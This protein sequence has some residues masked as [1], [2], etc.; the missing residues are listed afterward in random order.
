[1]KPGRWPGIVLAALIAATAVFFAVTPRPKPDFSKGETL[2]YE[3]AVREILRPLEYSGFPYI[4]KPEAAL[5]IDFQRHRWTLH[6]MR[7]YDPR[8]GVL[9]EQ[10]RYGLCAELASHVYQKL[11]PL[12]NKHYTL[13]FVK[14]TEPE[15]FVTP[16]STHIILLLLN[17]ANQNAYLIDPGFH[18]YGPE[19]DFHDYRFLATKDSMDSFEER[20]PAVTFP[21]GYAMP[22]LIRDNTLISFTADSIHGA[23]DRDN[24]RLLF[25][26]T[27]RKKSAERPL[28]MIGKNSGKLET[29]ED[30][31]LIAKTLKPGEVTLL[32]DKLMDWFRQ[33]TEEK[34]PP[35]NPRRTFF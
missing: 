21:A 28:L 2:P 35:G 34:T 24:F 16:E 7:H 14:A 20:S 11:K 17:K 30:Q 27:D 19:R 6:N 5:S 23:L 15:F 22:V 33:I 3:T 29:L 9:L 25:T 1:M 12:L 10:D 13:K 31:A 8:G 18:R 4:I 26:A 32:H